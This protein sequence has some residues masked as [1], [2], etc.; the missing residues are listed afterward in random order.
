MGLDQRTSRRLDWVHR[1]DAAVP[2][3]YC[4]A[5]L[6][7]LA[8]FGGGPNDDPETRKEECR[9]V[10]CCRKESERSGSCYCGKWENGRV[11]YA[12]AERSV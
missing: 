9:G 6:A 8:L 7:R 11:W 4:W 2:E 10:E 1:L 12:E 5:G 3:K